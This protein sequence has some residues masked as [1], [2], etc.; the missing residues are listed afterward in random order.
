[1]Y[2]YLALLLHIDVFVPACRILFGSSMVFG[3]QLMLGHIQEIK[4]R[5]SYIIWYLFV[6]NIISSLCVFYSPICQLCVL[7]L[8][9]LV[10]KVTKILYMLDITLFG[11]LY[12]TPSVCFFSCCSVCYC[13][14]YLACSCLCVGLLA[15]VPSHQGNHIY[16]FLMGAHHIFGPIWTW[17]EW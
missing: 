11:V 12:A 13:F 4:G 3:H 9:S 2:V 14:T 16:R 1:M 5:Q 7:N 10:H 17:K 8:L 6:K 15:D